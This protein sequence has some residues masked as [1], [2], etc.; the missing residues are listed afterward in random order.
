MALKGIENAK[1]LGIDGYNSLFFKEISK[2]VS[3]DMYGAII[4]F[5]D[6]GKMDNRVN[7]IIIT[8]VP[9]VPQSD[10]IK[11]FCPIS[12]CNFTYKIISRVLSHT[13]RGVVDEIVD[14]T[15]AGFIPGLQL[16]DNV[17]LATRK[18]YGRKYLT[19][20]CVIKIDMQKANDSI[21]WPFLE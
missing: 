7:Q 18:G 13:V 5:F 10:M 16:S 2:Y 21:E 3:N 12:C 15:Q 17:I 19:P 11:L 8:L 9:K 6:H 20:R 1:S 14:K 4:N